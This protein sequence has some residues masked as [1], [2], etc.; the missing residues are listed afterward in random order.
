MY[1][2]DFFDSLCWLKLLF[3]KLSLI[4][5]PLHCLCC[6]REEPGNEISFLQPLVTSARENQAA[7]GR[8]A[9]DWGCTVSG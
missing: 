9:C 5:W 4:L 8:G 1:K 2:S 6:L 7:S 3:Q